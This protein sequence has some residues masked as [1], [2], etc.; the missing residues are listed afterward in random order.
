MQKENIRFS[1][2][3]YFNI[4]KDLLFLYVLNHIQ[5]ISIETQLHT[6][7]KKYIFE[8]ICSKLFFLDWVHELKFG[9][10]WRQILTEWRLQYGF[11]I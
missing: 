9:A 1:I 11:Y 6:L 5:N 10:H 8:G 2:Y 7:F 4:Y 3:F